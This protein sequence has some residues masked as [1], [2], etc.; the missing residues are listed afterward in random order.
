MPTVI[1]NLYKWATDNRASLVLYGSRKS[2]LDYMLFAENPIAPLTTVFKGQW[3]G[4]ESCLC[5]TPEND[6]LDVSFIRMPFKDENFHLKYDMLRNSDPAP[7]WICD[8][9]EIRERAVNFLISHKRKQT[10][11]E[12]IQKHIRAYIVNVRFVERKVMGSNPLH[13]RYLIGR[14]IEPVIHGLIREYDLR[15]GG[16]GKWKGRDLESIL[17]PGQLEMAIVDLTL[18]TKAL[19]LAC[20]QSRYQVRY[21]LRELGIPEPKELMGS[22]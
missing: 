9:Y 18:T 22:L 13:G 15:R 4:K 10:S 7:E 16:M 2:D 20:V 17:S 3:V 8:H 21:W 5:I 1:E 12:E 14:C 11:D 19:A 6:Y